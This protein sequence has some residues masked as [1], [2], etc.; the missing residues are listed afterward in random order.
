MRLIPYKKIISITILI[1]L[2]V[3]AHIKSSKSSINRHVYNCVPLLEFQVP[4]TLNELLSPEGK[5]I[6]KMLNTFDEQMTS[7][8]DHHQITIINRQIY[9]LSR[10]GDSFKRDSS[11]A[12]ILHPDVPRQITKA[13]YRDYSCQE[14][15][16][17]RS[18]SLEGIKNIPNSMYH[19]IWKQENI[20]L[21]S[22]VEYLNN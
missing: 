16:P 11:G 22:F 21:Y 10:M 19:R 12:F 8:L 9:L 1:L 17:L 6:S 13:F 4:P 7:C 14:L 5:T 18:Q 15:T 3:I 20:A 2:V